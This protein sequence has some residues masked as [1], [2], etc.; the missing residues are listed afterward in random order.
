MK[1]GLD[2]F[3]LDVSLDEKFELIEAEFGLTG[4]SVVVKL[5]QR[6]YGGQGYY[7]EFTD[8]VALLFGQRI[9]L[10]GNVVS[11][12]V[13]AA[14]KRG[15]FDSQLYE[16]YN[17]LTSEGIQ[18]RYLE[19]VSRRKKVEIKKAY[20]LLCNTQISKNVYISGE[21]VDISL[22]NAYI[23]KQSK[24]EES[25]V[26]ESKDRVEKNSSDEL[27]APALSEVISFFES[28]ALKGDPE[29][30]FNYYDCRGWM[31]KGTP[32][33]SWQAAA[34]GWS[35]RE[36]NFNNPKENENHAA[37]DL[38]EYEKMLKGV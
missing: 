4:F 26:K 31:V 8:E 32:I 27:C 29:A 12:I 25:K 20:L 21:N 11:E 28:H 14:I 22:K 30:F 33:I 7:F 23:S 10:G 18:R 15:I 34:K 3:P 36:K 37:Y 16:K 9:G 6:I 38:D 24:V 2:Y 1:S 13:R 17:I 19:A 5:F 35:N